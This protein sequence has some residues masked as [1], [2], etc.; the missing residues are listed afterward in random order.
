MKSTIVF[1]VIAIVCDATAPA[2]PAGSGSPG[3]SCV[4]SL[5]SVSDIPQGPIDGKNSTFTLTAA[6]VSGQPIRDFRNG[7]ELAPNEAFQI[8]ERT[9]TYRGG[10]VPLPGDVD[11]LFYLVPCEAHSDGT[12]QRTITS[13]TTSQ[14]SDIEIRLL[15]RALQ[16][17]AIGAQ[18]A[19]PA[20]AGTL[21]G[22]PT[23]AR[24]DSM[25]S[26]MAER[27][28]SVRMLLSRLRETAADRSLHKQKRARGTEQGQP[29]AQGADGLGD[30]EG[31]NIFELLGAGEN[32]DQSRS[33]GVRPPTPA[34]KQQSGSHTPES[35]RMLAQKLDASVNNNREATRRHHQSQ[36]DRN[37]PQ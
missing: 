4:G 11:N 19:A 32:S 34:G 37:D 22:L 8:T 23:A 24:N 28:P 5:R 2:Q 9:L 13:E 16:N 15:R 1:L 25:A 10:Y 33:H 12:I 3:N 27:M 7:L 26:S 31:P 6:P 14:N 30:G 17:E 36:S 21:P 35:L 18:I 20:G 29:D